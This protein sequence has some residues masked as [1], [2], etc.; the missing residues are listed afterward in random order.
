MSDILDLSTLPP[1]EIIE[2]LDY[3][4]IVGRQNSK[5]T[6]I[7]A[8]TIAANPD[9]DLPPIDVLMLETDPA[10]IGNQAESFRE[11]ALRARV[12]DAIKAYMLAFSR[13][14]DLDMLAAFY[15]VVRLAGELDDRLRRR[16]VLAIQGRSTGGTVPRYRYVAMTSDLRVEDAIVYTVGRSPLIHV[17]LFSTDPDGVASAPLLAIVDAALHDPEVIM[18]NDT[19]VVASAVRLVVNPEADVWLLPDADA[20]TIARMELA[21]RSAWD[22]A[23]SLGRDFTV[24][25]WTSKLMIAGVHKIAPKSPLG[26]VGVPPDQAAGIGLVKLNLIGRAF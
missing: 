9:A 2:T 21:L 17:A 11:V 1:P 16:V 8:A 4:A 19:I 15:D 3:D 20:G 7:W 22:E 6:E 14:G 18:V 5:L 13:G 25:W 12:N 10:V 24:T 26:D 23:Q